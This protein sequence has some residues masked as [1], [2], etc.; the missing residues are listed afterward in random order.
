MLDLF[1]R[2]FDA[3]VYL[4]KLLPDKGKTAVVL[5]RETTPK[6]GKVNSTLVRR[7]HAKGF[8]RA[9]RPISNERCF[10]RVIGYRGS[11]DNAYR[12]IVELARVYR[13]IRRFF[14]VLVNLVLISRIERGSREPRR[15]YNGGHDKS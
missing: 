15:V 8:P 14:Y 5:I 9:E 12:T 1:A 10:K 3:N 4:H 13:L 2:F 6:T 11:P 7:G